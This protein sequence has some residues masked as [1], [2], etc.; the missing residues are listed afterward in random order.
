MPSLWRT[1]SGYACRAQCLSPCIQRTCFPKTGMPRFGMEIAACTACKSTSQPLLLL[2][3]S[4]HCFLPCCWL[5]TFQDQLFS[6]HISHQQMACP[7]TRQGLEIPSSLQIAYPIQCRCMSVPLCWNSTQP[8]PPQKKLTFGCRRSS[9]TLQLFQGRAKAWMG[10]L[11]T[12]NTSVS[13]HRG[14]WSGHPG[15]SPMPWASHPRWQTH[16]QN[17]DL[18]SS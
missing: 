3:A 13:V 5:Q 18:P 12:S 7:Q 9:W 2:F 1:S 6:S 4:M 17:A 14:S 10:S 11:L 16:C 15:S 8:C